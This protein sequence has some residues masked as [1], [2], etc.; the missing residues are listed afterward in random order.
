MNSWLKSIVKYST[1]STAYKVKFEFNLGIYCST[2]IN[3][4][5]ISRISF[6]FCFFFLICYTRMGLEP[7]TPPPPL[8]PEL[9]VL[10]IM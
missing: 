4:K 9:K 8:F 6:S 2:I 10:S 7:R 3:K 1:Y 5:A